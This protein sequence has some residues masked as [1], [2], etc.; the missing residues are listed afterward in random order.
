MDEKTL[1]EFSD[2]VKAIREK[3][4]AL[5]TKNAS[6]E[7]KQDELKMTIKS[8]ME[9]L[10]K[11]EI[12]RK[13]LALYAPVQTTKEKSPEYKAFL[14]WA[15]TGNQIPAEIK[16]L[17]VSDSTLGGYTTTP[18][19]TNELLKDLVEYSPIRSIARVRPTSKDSFPIRKK[20]GHLVARWTGETQQKTETTGVKFGLELVPT[21]ELY[22]QVD[23]SNQDLED[24][25]FNLE[26]ELSLEF[27][28]QFGV[29]EG[30]AFISGNSVGK[31]EGILM[32]SSVGSV[33]GG[34]ADSLTGD[35]LF[36]LYFA[37]K[38]AYAKNSKFIMNRQTMLAASI[39]KSAVDGQYLLRR[40]GESPV[41]SILG[42]DV[43]ECVDMPNVAAGTFPVAFGDFK[44]GYIIGDRIALSVLRDPYTAAEMNSVRFHARKRVA[45]QVVLAEAIKKL[46]IA[47]S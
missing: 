37:P 18:E 14:D 39:L 45:G 41:W 46:K 17:R 25:D 7:A 9:Q 36:K 15:R 23:I 19:I 13:R 5:E 10:D 32:N 42:A 22:A 1:L 44:R 6:Y 2:G 31:P 8:I 47:E 33:A 24:S 34:S 4:E 43:V 12:E 27:S 20:T 26:Q 40:L 29:A 30:A 28:E 21:H 35:A 16:L 11:M 38:S 3:Y